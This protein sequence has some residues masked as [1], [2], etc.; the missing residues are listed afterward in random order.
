M[1]STVDLHA[2]ENVGELKFTS[3]IFI[4]EWVGVVKNG[5]GLLGHIGL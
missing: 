1:E 2:N 5:H 3:I 4:F